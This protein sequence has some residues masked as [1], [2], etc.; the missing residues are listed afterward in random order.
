[1]GGGR[2]AGARLGAVDA[3]SYTPDDRDHSRALHGAAQTL[4]AVSGVWESQASLEAI[5]LDHLAE[6]HHRS[7][8]R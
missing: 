3:A 8:R 6:S 5:H 7:H 1:M 2:L 4:A